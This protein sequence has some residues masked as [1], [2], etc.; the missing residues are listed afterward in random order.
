MLE[1]VNSSLLNS[2]NLKVAS[3]KAAQQKVEVP[4]A[5]FSSIKIDPYLSRNVEFQ[6]DLSRAIVQIRDTSTGN[7]VKQFPTESQIQAY[8]QISSPPK[9]T[10]SVDFKDV[11]AKVEVR[12]EP[13]KLSPTPS[14]SS[15]DVAV[16][17]GAQG[18]DS[19]ASVNINA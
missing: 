11:E 15:L 8:K 1:A 9:E 2:G 10:P 13:Q 12:A 17:N 16:V 7:T 18:S 3:P 4:E 19:N 5:D 6:N 14:D